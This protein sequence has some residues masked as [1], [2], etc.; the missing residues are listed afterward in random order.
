MKHLP[1]T[2]ISQL[3]DF[4]KRTF[5]QGVRME[6]CSAKNKYSFIKT[7]LIKVRYARLERREKIVVLKYL[8]FLTGY[9][10]SHIKRCAKKVRSKKL[11]YNP[12]RKRNKFAVKYFA[13]DIALLIETDYLHDHLSGEATK[14]TLKREYDKFRKIEYGNISEISASHIYNI[15]K[16]NRQ[17][18][19]SKAKYYSRTKAVNTNL[20]KRCKP[21]PNGKPGFVRVDTVHQGDFNG[22]K[23]IYHINIVDEITQYEIVFSVSVIS[24]RYLE[25]VLKEMLRI[26]PFKV[27]EFHSDNGSE[28]INQIVVELLNKLHIRLT[29]SRSRH[30]NDNALVESKN[31]SIIRKVFG[32]N[33]ID[34]SFEKNLNEFNKNYLNIYLNGRSKK[35]I[36]Y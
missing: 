1:L 23:G 5:E 29:K 19:S 21:C 36:C 10:K 26:F 34:K 17:Y 9:S 27:Y 6:I 3:E 31:G 32:R 16:N 4:L 30:S 2:S 22:K 7:V 18:G 13:D 14:R 12:L 15:R 35:K 24:E 8:R 11:F 25:S 20:G 33:F 28:H